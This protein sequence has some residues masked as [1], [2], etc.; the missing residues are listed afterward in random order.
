MDGRDYTLSLKKNGSSS[1]KDEGKEEGKG[2]AKILR[3]EG[4]RCT[5]RLRKRF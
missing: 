4:K 2:R 3:Q 5:E 1:G